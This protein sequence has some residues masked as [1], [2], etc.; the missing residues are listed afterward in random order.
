MK[1]GRLALTVRAVSCIRP[2][3]T[4]PRYATM[5]S[6]AEKK[7]N[8]RTAWARVRPEK[9]KRQ[10]APRPAPPNVRPGPGKVAASFVQRPKCLKRKGEGS[11]TERTVNVSL[12]CHDLIARRRHGLFR[13]K[14][15]TSGAGAGR[16][17]VRNGD[18]G[19]KRNHC[20]NPHRTR[21][22]SPY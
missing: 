19:T 16:R 22:A 6:P 15:T 17:A 21:A 14:L 18:H 4:T 10:S 9:R 7:S 13:C 1:T 11:L 12:L 3:E 5:A 2:G 20:R 8:A